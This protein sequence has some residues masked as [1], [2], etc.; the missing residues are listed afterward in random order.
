MQTPRQRQRKSGLKMMKIFPRFRP[1]DI[2]LIYRAA[3]LRN[4]SLSMF[5]AKPLLAYARKTIREFEK[6][7]T[8]V[9]LP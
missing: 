5:A 3:E 9:I 6:E 1:D 8:P 7:A 4:E 2:Q